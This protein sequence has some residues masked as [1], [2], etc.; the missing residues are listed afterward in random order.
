MKKKYM[1]KTLTLIGKII[2]VKMRAG[3]V[4]SKGNELG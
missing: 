4:C 1:K 2:C 3:V